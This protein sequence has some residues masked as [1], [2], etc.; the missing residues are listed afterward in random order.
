VLDLGAWWKATTG[1]PLPLGGNVIRKDIPSAVRKEVAEI[2]SESIDYGLRNR[3]A[4]IEH[5]MP[6][7][8][9]LDLDRADRFIGMYVNEFTRDYG[10]IG[11]QAVSRFLAEASDHGL[12]PKPVALEFVE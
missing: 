10:K 4:G 6:L 3:Q 11:R 9:G 2:L 12:I 7:A 1:L 5:S 8:R